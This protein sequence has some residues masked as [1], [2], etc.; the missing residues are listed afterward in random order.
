[1]TEDWLVDLREGA[2]TF[3]ITLTPEQESLFV[4]FMALLLARNSYV[5]L[6]AIIEPREVAIKHYL[7]SLLV[8]CVWSPRSG[9]RAVDIG[10][11]GGFPGIPLAIRYPET[12][13]LLT[14]S[15]H[16]KVDF[17]REAIEELGLLN[18]VPYWGRAELLGRDD[19]YRGKYH[20][21]LVRAVA[22]LGLL[23]EYA[24]PLLQTG[25]RLI[26]M[27]GPSG[28][29]EISESEQALQALGGSV[30]EV[31]RLQLPAAGERLLVVVEKIRPTPAQYPRE[32]SAMKK[33]PLFLDSRRSTP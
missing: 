6:T 24:L 20:I 33:K 23:L 17:L 4:R 10:T 9:E 21:V 27:K 16:K 30:R 25:G 28:E 13:F 8:E 32:G 7:D 22:H 19:N 29:A 2:A 14:D 31:R 12:H 26:A 11:G 15:A 1:M 3:D 18:A 5:N